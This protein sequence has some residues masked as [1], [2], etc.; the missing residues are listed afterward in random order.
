MNKI[1][2]LI[3]TFFLLSLYSCRDNR[4]D[5]QKANDYFKNKKYKEAIIYFRK[6]IKSDIKDNPILYK[7]LA[8]S[9]IQIGRLREGENYIKRL[10]NY[11]LMMIN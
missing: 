11:L 5:Y 4:S 3:F 1:I 8:D 9:Y 6:S 10:S 2:Y 7:K